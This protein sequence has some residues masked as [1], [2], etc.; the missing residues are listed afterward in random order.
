[1]A[2]KCFH[3]KPTRLAL[4]LTVVVAALLDLHNLGSQPF[5]YDEALSD[6]VARSYGI[7]FV[8]LA[9]ER[10]ASMAF[11]HLTLHAWLMLLPPSDFDIRLLS[12]IC[13]VAA[14]P[15]LYLL[16]TTLFGPA[17]GLVAAV[18][19]AVNP[20]FL[21]YAQEARSYTLTVFLTLV[22]WLF[23]I[24]CSREPKLLN[25]LT[26]IGATTLAIYSHNL[27]MLILPAQGT[28]ILFLQR[29]KAKRL[30]VAKAIC[31]V[32]VLVLPLFFIAAHW[33]SGDPDWIAASIGSPGLRS[34]REV[35]VSFA[36]AIPPPRIRQRLLEA[37]FAAGFFMCLERFA[38]A[39][40]SRAAEA[41]GYACVAAAFGI[42][43]ALL[44]GVSQL[45]ALFIVRYVLICLPFLLTIIAAGWVGFPRRRVAAVALTLLVALSLWSDQAYYSHPSK[46]AWREAIRYIA[47]CARYD[48]KLGF[49]PA[50]GRLEFE[51]NVRRF[52]GGG[53]LPTIIYPRWNSV[54]EVAGQYMENPAVM[55][56][57]LKAPYQRLWIV[58]SHLMG[59]K[60]NQ[61]L[62]GL[63]AE[64]PIVLRKEFRGISIIFCGYT[65]PYR[66]REFEMSGVGQGI[67]AR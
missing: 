28:A 64:Y 21:S 6:A 36:G 60:D 61:V 5:W 41:D 15:A 42:P 23:V 63:I 29:E 19:L 38:T 12:T 32:S 49:I 8:K 11:Y 18:L 25:L 3:V 4:A 33:Y 67:A 35:A 43:I 46:P 17:V 22:S 37:L 66:G 58:Q 1:M 16:A 59:D 10:E 31:A 55:K 65:L 50:S 47:E 26:Y 56:A 7:D 40:R 2:K 13:A 24:K 9:F 57:V 30:R 14:V 52:G 34:L 53:T 45:L 27:G 62:N 51:H 48:D 54:F 20:L 44:M 39:A